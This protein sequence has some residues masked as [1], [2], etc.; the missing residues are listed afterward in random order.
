[1]YVYTSLSAMFVGLFLT[2]SE[3]IASVLV[4]SSQRDVSGLLSATVSH[5][6][7]IICCLGFEKESRVS[8]RN[9]Q[10]FSEKQ[11]QRSLGPTEHELKACEAA[12]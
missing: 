7:R 4:S 1:M 9:G 8:F 3:F 5:K 2:T 6:H 10:R 12:S 11:Q